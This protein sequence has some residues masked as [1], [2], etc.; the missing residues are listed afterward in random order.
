[1]CHPH[2]AANAP[3]P[4]ERPVPEVDELQDDEFV[5]EETPVEAMSEEP[6]DVGADEDDA[7]DDDEDE[8]A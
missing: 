8:D 5:I 3:E 2:P 7:D 1:M 6:E 4:L